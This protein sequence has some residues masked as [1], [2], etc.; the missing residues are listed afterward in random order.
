MSTFSSWSNFG[1]SQ[2]KNFQKNI[3]ETKT[4]FTETE[5]EFLLTT[6][7]LETKITNPSSSLSQ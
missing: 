1:D 4:Y 2:M 6:E 3:A 7:L 5:S